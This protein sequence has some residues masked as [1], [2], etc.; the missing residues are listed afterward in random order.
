MPNSTDEF[1]RT[2]GLAHSEWE[3]WRNV[4]QLLRRAGLDVDSTAKGNQLCK[5]IE[6]WGERL[7]TI[8]RDQDEETC[9][10]VLGEKLAAWIKVRDAY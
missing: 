7:V 6:L 8:R 10:R 9:K 4:C 2:Q 1:L 3:A 5:A